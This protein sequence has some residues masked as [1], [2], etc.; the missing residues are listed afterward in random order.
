MK[1][2]L[3][4]LLAAAL[5]LPYSCTKP[6]DPSG[7]GTEQNGGEENNGGNSGDN[8]GG[9]T[10][11][12]KTYKPGDYYKVGLAEG[13]VAYVD[14]TGTKGM[15]ISLDETTAAWS[16]EYI[17]MIDQGMS[18]S[19]ED[20]QTN[21]KYIKEVEGWKE[22]FPAFAWC[23]SKNA[24]GLSS[25]YLP[26][27]NE[28]EYTAAAFDAI[29]ATLNELGHPL[30]SKNEWYWTSMEGGSTMAYPFSFA[31]GGYESATPNDTDKKKEHRVRAMRKF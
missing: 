17:G 24:L 2:I 9:E 26:T 13:I 12:T 3:T 6:D 20:G 1:K 22:M 27:L 10:P 15:L 19:P 31:D 4:L 23:D 28:L 7:T 14:T 11:E 5:I 8:G 29:N 18:F 30:L 16:T 21:M 25:W